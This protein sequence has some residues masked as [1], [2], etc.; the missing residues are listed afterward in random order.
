MHESVAPYEP[1]S[2]LWSKDDSQLKIYLEEGRTGIADLVKRAGTTRYAAEPHNIIFL[3]DDEA[4]D[5]NRIKLLLATGHK[6]VAVGYARL[7]S[8]R[9]VRFKSGVIAP[10]E[11]FLFGIGD[12]PYG[13][14]AAKAIRPRLIE[15]VVSGEVPLRLTQ[16]ERPDLYVG[17][18]VTVV[19]YTADGFI[20]KNSWGRDWG[21]Q[22][23]AIVSFDYHRLFCDE[24]LAVKEPSI[25]VTPGIAGRNPPLYLKSCP[26]GTG[27]NS[28]LRLSLF[29]PREGGLAD[30]RR[31]QFEV[32]EQDPTGNRGRL[33]EF[34]PPNAV[35]QA[36]N[37]FPVEV[38][39]GRSPAGASAHGSIGSRC[40]SAR[41]MNWV[42]EW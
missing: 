40:L 25:L 34:P 20:I 15:E 23:Y 8:P 26:M 14:A 37:G 41:P 11:G 32:Y 29:G 3:K 42:A 19:G 2:G 6:A 24:A 28:V 36:G 21:M 17:H 38:L 18:A 39:R 13:L 27:T 12:K 4:R 22:G 35:G 7:Y 30:I 5:I 9:W 16:P 33:V 31:P 10:D 1:K